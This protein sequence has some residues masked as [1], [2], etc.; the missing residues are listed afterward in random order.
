MKWTRNR[1]VASPTLPVLLYDGCHPLQPSFSCHTQ[2]APSSSTTKTAKMACSHH[3]PQLRP[4]HRLPALQPT[5][6]HHRPPEGV[7]QLGSGTR[8][9][10]SS[11]LFPH[12]IP[13]MLLELSQEEEEATGTKL[14]RTPGAIG[15]SRSGAF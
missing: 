11:L 4:W 15:R 12:G 2:M 13:S 5:I 8:W 6:R 10:V 9:T 3:K 1:R 14:R 7:Q